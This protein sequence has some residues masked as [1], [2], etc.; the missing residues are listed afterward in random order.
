MQ[1]YGD[2]FEKAKEVAFASIIEPFGNEGPDP[3]F[4]IIDGALHAVEGILPDPDEVDL[5]WVLA[6]ISGKP[7]VL[8]MT[9]EPGT[10][11]EGVI[12]A[13]RDIML[14]DMEDELADRARDVGYDILKP[15]AP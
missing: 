15:P 4:G 1:T 2:L 3:M 7:E 12:D 6:M 11:A 14:D 8:G 9:V 5:E 10:L 13:L